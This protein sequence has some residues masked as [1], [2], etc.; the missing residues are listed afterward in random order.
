[1]YRLRKYKEHYKN[2]IRLAAPIVL[3][4]IGQVV[5]QIVDNAMVGQL[6]ATQL[7]AASFAGSIFFMLFVF[8]M[9]ISMGLTPLVGENF[10]QRR[11]G[12]SSKYLQNA[13][14]IYLVIAAV[15]FI[16]Q[17]TTIPVLYHLGQPEEVV[18]MAIPYYKLLVWSVIPFMLFAVFKQFLEG[19]GNTK[20]TMYVVISTNLLNILGNYL[21]IYGHWGFPAMG[22]MGAGLSTLISRILMPLFIF[23][24]FIYKE[25]LRRYLRMFAWH[26]LDARYIRSLFSVGFPISMQIFLEVTAFSLSAIM[27]GWIG[28]AEIAGNQIALTL[29]NFA[30]MA[31]VGVASATT[32]RVSHLFGIGNLKQLN[33]AVI[34]SWHIGLCWNFITAST[35][36]LLR[37]YLP[38]IF[39]QDPAVIEVA[40]TLLIFAG[41]YQFSDGLQCLTIGALRGI[42][43]VR[44]IMIRAFISYILICLP[45]G[46]LCAFTFGMGV[47]GIWLG[48]IV[49]LSTASVLLIIRYRH[50]YGVLRRAQFS[51]RNFQVR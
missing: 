51:Q 32:I 15:I 10:S 33:R 50:S 22:V 8:V 12:E 26:R 27:V 23:S 46:Y 16:I 44:S 24:Y 35:Y 40:S 20:V 45:V 41:L 13:M 37:N 25:Q 17:L 7:A 2:N 1:M 28:T 43:D 3:S 30:F 4:Q 42:Q 47:S 6:G 29:S 38:R 34:A 39:T 21:L 31:V 5:V 11:Y 19:I 48:F 14:V 49:G 18:E 9:G 36:I